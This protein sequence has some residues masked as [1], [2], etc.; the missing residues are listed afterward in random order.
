MAA[1]AELAY[2]INYLL[3]HTY[4]CAREKSKSTHARR[5]AMADA[6]SDKAQATMRHASS[7]MESRQHTQQRGENTLGPS[8]SGVGE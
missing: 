2:F 5:H 6:T 8:K 7:V 1:P 4:V 3:S